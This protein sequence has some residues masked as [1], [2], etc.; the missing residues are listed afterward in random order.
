M[1]SALKLVT[2]RGYSRVRLADIAADAG[3]SKATVYHY[4]A[5]K[6]DL[7]TRTI[8]ERIAE[9]HAASEKLLALTG[10][11]ASTRIRVFLDHFWTFCLTRRAGIWQRLL[12]S[13][14][15]TEA[16]PV[17]RTWGRGLVQRWNRVQ[18]LIEEGQTSGEFRS[19]VDAAVAARLIISGLWHQAF[20]HV[21]LGV[22]KIEP[23]ATDR[24]FE[25]A[26]EQ[27]LY[28]LRPSAVK[29]STPG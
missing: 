23:L 19:D 15:V 17:F 24:I 7:L 8:S 2:Q 12:V 16:P 3:V 18:R 6:D 28:S 4:F 22:N 1:A 27:F 25:S 11:S 29:A 9:K 20:F 21:H 26:V 14:I 5:D 13:E 10:G